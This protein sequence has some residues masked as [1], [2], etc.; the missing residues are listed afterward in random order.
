MECCCAT[1]AICFET[2]TNISCITKQKMANDYM[3]VYIH[4]Y[5]T[6]Q[7]RIYEIWEAA[8]L[9]TTTHRKMNRKQFS[10]QALGKVVHKKQMAWT[11]FPSPQTISRPNH[12]HIRT[13]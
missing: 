12:D 8:D 7:A 1:N 11:H 3:Y 10:G 5:N 9:N 4:I 13:C 2:K 6:T